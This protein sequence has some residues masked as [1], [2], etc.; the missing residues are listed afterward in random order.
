MTARA[1]SIL[2]V[3]A[4][5]VTVAPSNASRTLLLYGV[6]QVMLSLFVTLADA[7]TLS[8][9]SV[10]CE[11]SAQISAWGLAISILVAVAF[12]ISGGVVF[13]FQVL[14][15][16]AASLLWSRTRSELVRSGH[17]MLPYASPIAR[18]LTFLV[19][20][21]SLPGT[22]G[23]WSV[24]I[25][26]LVLFAV[27]DR[28]PRWPR[29]AVVLTSVWIGQIMI[30]STTL[31]TRWLSQRELSTNAIVDFEISTRLGIAVVA[32]VSTGIGSEVQRRMATTSPQRAFNMSVSIS[33]LILG[34]SGL[35]AAGALLAS[36]FSWWPE[37]LLGMNS[38]LAVAAYGVSAAF[39]IF[40]RFQLS[41][42]LNRQ[43][44]LASV[45]CLVAGLV[46]VILLPVSVPN[47]LA[48]ILVSQSAGLV[49]STVSSGRSA[50]TSSTSFVGVH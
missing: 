48:S 26:S 8:S 9:K 27:T 23:S 34:I 14:I 10:R 37:R 39:S 3:V 28:R 12:A 29:V 6:A 19:L 16:A 15:A 1:S 31:I 47:L 2:A 40:L 18:D 11:S 20:A 41:H 45:S 22:H 32:L 43:F 4:V 21:I 33:A 5:G 36:S 7:E 44:L 49:I 13:G 24:P 50:R 17:I 25:A 30:L 35:V 42:Q 38:S 46:A